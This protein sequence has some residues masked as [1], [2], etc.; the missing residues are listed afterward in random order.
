MKWWNGT[1]TKLKPNMVFVYGSNPEGRH[2]LGAAKLALRYGAKY[3]VGR[4]LMGQ[5]Y[6]LVTKNLK[7]GFVE[8]LPDGR[9][10]RY[11]TEGPCSVGLDQIR[12]NIVELYECAREH[13]DKMF[14]VVQKADG[15]G[16]NGYSPLELWKGFTS[17]IEVPDNI[18]FHN[19]FKRYK[20]VPA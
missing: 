8:K 12:E 1:I 18:Y 16:L 3:G 17:F 2:G 10:I 4:G 9:E 15:H 7:A 19:S 14:I 11:P 20:D 6:A 5:T 13:P